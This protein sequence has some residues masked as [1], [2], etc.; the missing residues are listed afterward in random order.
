[1]RVAPTALAQDENAA[2]GTLFVKSSYSGM[3]F[4][5]LNPDFIGPTAKIFQI[6][7]VS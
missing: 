1:M 4:L 6:F 5:K 3:V 2:T 7:C